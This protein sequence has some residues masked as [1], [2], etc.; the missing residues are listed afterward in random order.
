[1]KKFFT[2]ACLLMCALLISCG[3]TDSLHQSD[4][5][6]ASDSAQ[7]VQHA[8]TEI[9]H[10]NE[11]TSTS[12]VFDKTD[13][14]LNPRLFTVT[15]LSQLQTIGELTLVLTYET[16]SDVSSYLNQWLII[17]AI[18]PY[19]FSEE[20]CAIYTNYDNTLYFIDHDEFITAL[21]APKVDGE[22]GI[23][24]LC[25][26][27]EDEP[28]SYVMRDCIYMG[29]SATEM[30]NL[31][32]SDDLSSGCQDQTLEDYIQSQNNPNDP[33]D[34]QIIDGIGDAFHYAAQDPNQ[35]QEDRE[36]VQAF[37]DAWDFV[38]ALKKAG[39]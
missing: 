39:Y 25:Y 11:I 20:R 24:V 9:D 8:A 17:E 3:N 2:L 33:I 5:S 6:R 32:S 23:Q 35:S 19:D 38:A 26:L 37:G 30:D 14:D 13:P 31:G 15:D 27:T 7:I 10:D 34:D 18:T 1:M 29:S 16:T 21:E 28:G 12:N 36:L 22:S 4:D